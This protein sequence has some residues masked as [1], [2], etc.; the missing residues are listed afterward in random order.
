MRYRNRARRK[1]NTHIIK[2]ESESECTRW[3]ILM[4]QNRFPAFWGYHAL[5]NPIRASPHSKSWK[6]C[7]YIDPLLLCNTTI[8]SPSIPRAQ[9]KC[10]PSEAQTTQVIGGC[11][12]SVCGRDC[13][14]KCTGG[15]NGLE[16][17]VSN[18]AVRASGLI[19]T[20]LLH[21]S[22]PLRYCKTGCVYRNGPRQHSSQ[23]R[24]LMV[25]V[26]PLSGEQG[27]GGCPL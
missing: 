9:D 2:R 17:G 1:T 22:R 18:S 16:P 5:P 12:L 7:D 13:C 25:L 15:P 26:R 27:C 20:M 10:A 23:T 3:C 24:R 11:C 6:R 8:C 21:H 4:S 19:F 14:A